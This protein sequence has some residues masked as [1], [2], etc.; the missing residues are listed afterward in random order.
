MS[1][2]YTMP[3]DLAEWFNTVTASILQRYLL[4][5]CSILDAGC[6]DGRMVDALPAD[7]SYCGVDLCPEY[8]DQARAA[9]PQRRFEVGDIRHLYP[10][11]QSFD[12]AVARGVEGPIRRSHGNGVWEDVQAE[13]LRVARNVLLLNL[14]ATVGSPLEVKHVSLQGLS[15]VLPG[16]GCGALGNEVAGRAT[17]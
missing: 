3:A 6:G 4:P 11:S 12:W 13:L 9:Y 8:L 14:P 17:G 5:G 2:P 16:R 15:Y 7:V 1:G 10:E